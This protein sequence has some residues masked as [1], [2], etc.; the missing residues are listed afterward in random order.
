MALSQESFTPEEAQSFANKLRTFANE[1]TPKERAALRMFFERV[2]NN[3]D[4]DVAGHWS[5]LDSVYDK[6][7]QQLPYQPETHQS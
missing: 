2:V 1:L 3:P 5:D 4:E 6:L 7:M